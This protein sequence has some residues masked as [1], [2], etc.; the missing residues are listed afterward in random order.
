MIQVLETQ[1]LS[2]EQIS[3]EASIAHYILEPS[4]EALGA[5][6]EMHEAARLLGRRTMS[7]QTVRRGRQI[8]TRIAVARFCSGESRANDTA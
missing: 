7:V 2:D 6:R 8:E 5:D 3:A 4:H 1:E